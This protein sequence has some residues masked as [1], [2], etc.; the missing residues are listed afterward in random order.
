MKNTENIAG[1]VRKEEQGTA[2]M[3]YATLSDRNGYG[4]RPNMYAGDSNEGVYDAPYEES[5]R[6]LSSGGS[7]HYE[8]SPVGGRNG[9][10]VTINGVAVR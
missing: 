7:S 8:P 2:V 9:A 4:A 10:T 5:P 1:A 6:S 3:S